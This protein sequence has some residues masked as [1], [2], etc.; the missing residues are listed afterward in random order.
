MKKIK[1]AFWLLV[2]VAIGLIGF[3][4]Q[5]FFLSRPQ[6]RINLFLREYHVD[7]VPIAVMLF[8]LFLFGL[9]SAYISS[10]SGRFR[11]NRTVKQLNATVADHVDRISRLQ[12]E[13]DTIRGPAGRTTTEQVG[14][15]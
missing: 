1:I 9:L 13:V 7:Q 11:H 5:E 10:L 14:K 2:M 4:N 15:P 3:Q 8:G 6:L 12:S